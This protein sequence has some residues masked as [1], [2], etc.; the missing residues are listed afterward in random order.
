[1][2]GALKKVD[3]VKKAEVR[4][5]Q[6][7]AFVEFDPAKVTPEQLIAATEKVGFRASVVTSR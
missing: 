7:Q 2:A 1:M 6:G 4:W 3:G 5:E